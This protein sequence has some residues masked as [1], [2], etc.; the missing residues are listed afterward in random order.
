MGD[1]TAYQAVLLAASSQSGRAGGGGGG[2]GRGRGGGAAGGGRE[3]ASAVVERMGRVVQRL[4]A[5]NAALQKKTVSNVEHVRLTKEA[6]AHKARAAALQIELDAAAAKA[7]AARSEIERAGKYCR[8]RDEA[9]R[10]LKAEEA[11]SEALGQR[12]SDEAQARA[13]AE[14]ALAAAGATGAGDAAVERLQE[15]LR[16]AREEL[17]HKGGQVVELG[18]QLQEALA[19]ADEA[20][21]RAEARHS[22]RRRAPARGDERPL[23]GLPSPQVLSADG[24]RMAAELEAAQQRALH[25]LE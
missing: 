18:T 20:T 13:A 11:R 25:S 9:R 21:R 24:G 5:E 3:E 16:E 22:P 7:A 19:A 1:L 4:Q 10:A 12:L 17:L 6:K 8:E 2:R 23:S 14:E 15:A